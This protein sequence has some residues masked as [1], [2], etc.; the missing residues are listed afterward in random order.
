[1]SSEW[2]IPNRAAALRAQ[3]AEHLQR[4]GVTVD[5]EPVNENGVYVRE[6][7]GGCPRIVPVFELVDAKWTGAVPGDYAC[8]ACR[9]RLNR[10]G[11]LGAADWTAA[12]GAPSQLVERLRAVDARVRGIDG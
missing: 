8:G 4:I 5:P 9:G 11:V 2:R 10:A 1:M 6:R 12:H 7:C 3:A